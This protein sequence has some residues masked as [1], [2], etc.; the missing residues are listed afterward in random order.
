M[1]TPTKIHAQY[2]KLAREFSH[3]MRKARNKALLGKRAFI[4][5]VLSHT[6]P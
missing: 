1:N 3:V 6:P 5:Q 2:H 4:K